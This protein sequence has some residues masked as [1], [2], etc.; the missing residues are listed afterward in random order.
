MKFIVFLLAI[1]LYFSTL[2]TDCTNQF[3]TRNFEFIESEWYNLSTAS[4]YATV[5]DSQ[6]ALGY[7]EMDGF[8]YSFYELEGMD[9][10]DY[11][12]SESTC[13]AATGIFTDL[14]IK[15]GAAE[16]FLIYNVKEI[17]IKY[18]HRVITITDEKTLEE[19]IRIFRDENFSAQ[20]V[21]PNLKIGTINT[22]I[23]FDIESNLTWACTV[24]KM[25]NNSIKLFY[26]DIWT[27]ARLSCDVT[28]IFESIM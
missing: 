13:L 6:K 25:D 5:S 21:D 14:W 10:E 23:V 19:F 4:F 8:T 7:Y 26:S 2:I 22:E 27:G 28:S 9:K 12:I 17:V 16:P 15:K 1:F 18:D 3:S 20:E 24:Q 11:L